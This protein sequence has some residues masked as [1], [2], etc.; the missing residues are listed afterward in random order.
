MARYALAK[1]RL[2]GEIMD[3]PALDPRHHADALTGLARLNA[4]SGAARRLWRQIALHARVQPGERLR[5]VDVASGGGDLAWGLWTQA[6][7]AGVAL[8]IRGIDVSSTACAFA[9]RRCRAAGA[10][11]R[12]ERA[13]ALADP[14]PGADVAISSLFLHH[15]PHEQAAALLGKMAAAAPLVV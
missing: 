9:A 4:L 14:I 5:V 8:E 6:R 13:D 3:S 11:I 12:F 10:A 2:Q 15:L 7:R 1:R